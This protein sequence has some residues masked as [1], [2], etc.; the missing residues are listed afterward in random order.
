MTDFAFAIFLRQ[1]F[2]L[3]GG[4]TAADTLEAFCFGVKLIVEQLDADEREALV[5]RVEIAF[6]DEIAIWEEH[7]P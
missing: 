5:E 4:P 2:E 6:A 7:H 3:A 1:L